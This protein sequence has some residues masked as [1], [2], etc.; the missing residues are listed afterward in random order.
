M[1]SNELKDSFLNS[2]KKR[3]RQR[4]R[5]RWIVLNME[6]QLINQPE[7][8]WSTVMLQWQKKQ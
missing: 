7:M 3:D 5:D 1:M 2:G 4:M 6:T 8:S